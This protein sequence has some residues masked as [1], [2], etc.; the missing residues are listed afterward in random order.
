[1]FLDSANATSPGGSSARISADQ[2]QQQHACVSIRAVLSSLPAGSAQQ[3]PLGLSSPQQHA[4]RFK[5]CSNNKDTAAARAAGAAP[6]T[7]PVREVVLLIPLQETN[8]TTA[9]AASKHAK[10]LN[11]HANTSEATHGSSRDKAQPAAVSRLLL[12]TLYAEQQ[13]GL[14]TY[15]W[16]AS[17][18]VMPGNI[19]QTSWLFR[20]S[21][22]TIASQLSSS[23]GMPLFSEVLHER[24]ACG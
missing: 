19:Q 24:T 2:Q 12:L 20:L 22:T 23:S 14:S 15:L 13:L 1:M 8:T 9:A 7:L 21:I 5:V 6:A 10:S 4:S 16:T 3:A 11:S 17:Q 18:L